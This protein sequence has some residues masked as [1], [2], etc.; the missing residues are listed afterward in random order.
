MGSRSVSR[1]RRGHNGAVLETFAEM[2]TIISNV[3]FVNPPGKHGGKGSTK[4][5]NELLSVI[6][7]STDYEM[8]KRRLQNWADYRFVGGADALPDGLRR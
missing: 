6:D 8:F 2:R 7:S 5:H 1:D 3:T 4:A